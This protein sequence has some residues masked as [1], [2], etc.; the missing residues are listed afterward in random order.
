MNGEKL[1]ITVA[2]VPRVEEV[3][4][5]EAAGATR[6]EIW[7]SVLEPNSI[8]EI[9]ATLTIP[10]T[11]TRWEL[12][13]VRHC[14][15][16]ERRL[17]EERARCAAQQGGA[18][19]LRARNL[20]PEAG[21]EITGHIVAASA[22]SL[23]VSLK[24]RNV[25]WGTRVQAEIC[26]VRKGGHTRQLAYATLTPDT[27]GAV[28]WDVPVPAGADGDGLVLLYRQCPRGVVCSN[29]MTRLATYS[30]P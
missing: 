12:V 15:V 16:D 23:Q 9:D 25:A 6:E 26:R 20:M 29:R 22:K 27:G 10:V 7:Q 3:E 17:D 14:R 2:G 30:L 13:T 28:T 19:A 21:A 4:P 1:L 8:D 18:L 24:A 5:R 11:P